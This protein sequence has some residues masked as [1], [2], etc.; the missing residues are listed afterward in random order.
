VTS[1]PSDARRKGSALLTVMWISAGLA[2]IAFTLASTVRVESERAAGAVE[3]L[4]ARYLAR[5]SI[6]RAILRLGWSQ[7][8][9]PDGSPVFDE[10][11]APRMYFEFPTGRAEVRI[12][13]ESSKINIKAA[14]PEVIY[15]LLLN[16]G[17]DPERAQAITAGIL[18]RRNPAAAPQDQILNPGPTFP[19]RYPSFEEI[20][21][22]LFVSGMTPELYY[23]SIERGEG[24]R[25]APRAGLRDCATVY[26]ASG[27]VDANSA[28]PAVLSALGLN[29]QAIAL[30]VAQREI[31][32][33]RN[34]QQLAGVLGDD[35]AARF[36]GI[37][38]V[39][40]YT[41]RASAQVRLPNGAF[42]Q[43]RRSVEAMVKRMSGTNVRETYRVLR[44][45]DQVWAR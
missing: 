14:P 30:L 44:W 9:N 18:A 25:L 39:A 10:Q 37:G 28:E 2:A 4:R 20:E 13:P 36:V 41:L 35:P 45:Y 29:P 23:G 42:S 40:I 38:G 7:F 11:G 26:G 34:A 5:G 43:D 31:G 19:S 24:G 15:R 32:P 22:L 27:A 6:Q 21:E 3:S 8:R 1:R 12:I 17:A 16:L 33:I